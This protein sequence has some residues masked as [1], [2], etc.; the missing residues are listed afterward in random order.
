MQAW[1]QTRHVTIWYAMNSWRHFLW[2]SRVTGLWRNWSPGV[3]RCVRACARAWVRVDE[4]VCGRVPV[5]KWVTIVNIRTRRW[6]LFLSEAEMCSLPVSQR[7]C[8][9]SPPAPPHP[10]HPHP[11]AVCPDHVMTSKT[12]ISN[13]SHQQLFG[14]FGWN[15]LV[16]DDIR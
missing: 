9:P 13:G 6:L 2:T 10:P 8:P 5:S 3:E 14:L 4:R 16:M 12:L 11:I 15:G 7:I 1:H